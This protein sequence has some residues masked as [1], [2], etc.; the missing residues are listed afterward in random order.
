MENRRDTLKIIGAIGA[1][2]AFP[3][4]A[5]ELYAQHAH[6]VP[7]TAPANAAGP[8]HPKFLNGTEFETVSIVAD[9][10]IPPTDTPGATAAGVPAYIDTVLDANSEYQHRFRT[11]LK[12]LDNTALKRFGKPFRQLD[13]RSQVEILTPLSEAVDKGDARSEGEIFFRAMKSLTADGYYTSRI[14]LV[15]ELQYKG[16]TVLAAFPPCKHPEHRE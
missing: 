4:S 15:D 12:W 13:E 5:D 10:I 7:T 6:T 2:C 3:F 1:T 8:Y 16:N 9:L 11:G 14:G